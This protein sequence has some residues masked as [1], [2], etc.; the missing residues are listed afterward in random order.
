MGSDAQHPNWSI[1][2]WS[3]NVSSIC[4]LNFSVANTVIR[5]ESYFRINVCCDIINVQRKQQGTKDSVLWDTRQNRDPIRFCSVYNSSL[6]IGR[7]E[8]IHF[9]VFSP[10]PQPNSLLLRSSCVGVSN[11]FSKS[12]MNV[13][14]C[15]PLS[16]ILA[17]S[18]ITVVNWVSQLCLF[19]N[20]CCLSVGG[21]DV[22]RHYEWSWI[23]T[24]GALP[25]SRKNTSLPDP[26]QDIHSWVAG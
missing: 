11:A 5:K 22:D 2:F 6:S 16:K 26:F 3:F 8:T 1:S 13:S 15:P 20:A 18:F 12:K 14:T 25:Y 10:M 4:I 23:G 7:K 21:T 9:S 17:Q 19:L 24:T